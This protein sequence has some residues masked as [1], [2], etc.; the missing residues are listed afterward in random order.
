MLPISPN[1][2]TGGTTV[3]TT[4][5]LRGKS[6]LV[7]TF[8]TVTSPATPAPT[9]PGTLTLSERLAAWR[10]AFQTTNPPEQGVV[11]GVT[12][13]LVV[14]RAG[15]LP[16][17]LFSGLLALLLAAVAEHPPGS[18]AAAHG[19]DWLGIVLAIIG[20]LLAHVANNMMNDLADTEV[21]N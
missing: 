5:G 20:I 16:L 8:A 10:Y 7:G 6:H 18:Y 12:K 13:W 2:A 4:V 3:V 11:D 19:V 21:G 17:T 14:T 9:T 15:V 1:N